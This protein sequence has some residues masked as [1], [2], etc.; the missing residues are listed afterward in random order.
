MA[1]PFDAFGSLW[2]PGLLL[3]FG[4]ILKYDGVINKFFRGTVLPYSVE[5]S[6][7]GWALASISNESTVKS[8]IVCYH[9]I[10]TK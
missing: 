3:G 10:T 1:D 7:L 2:N 8:A 4:F 6:P 9:N 5:W